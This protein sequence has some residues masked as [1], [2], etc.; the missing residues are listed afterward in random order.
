M[1]F[2]AHVGGLVSCYPMETSWEEWM[3]YWRPWTVEWPCLLMLMLVTL[4]QVGYMIV[5][6]QLEYYIKCPLFSTFCFCF[7]TSVFFIPSHTWGYCIA[8]VLPQC[9]LN[10]LQS[11]PKIG[12]LDV[13]H[14][15]SHIAH[16]TCNN[17]PQ[18]DGAPVIAT[19]V[20]NTRNNINMSQNVTI[21]V[22]AQVVSFGE[23]NG[24]LTLARVDNCTKGGP[25]DI[26]TIC[27]VVSV[28]C[29]LI[30]VCLIDILTVGYCLI[31]NFQGTWF[32]KLHV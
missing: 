17:K 23:T 25:L 18:Y 20:M 28:Q 13:Q 29:K 21:K 8:S 16:N 6:A 1:Q 11:D 15:C 32:N 9:P 4:P 5:T 30:F 26:C 12:H 27:K 31:R 2:M 10:S 14:I 7:H 24:N 22:A 3:M 19:A